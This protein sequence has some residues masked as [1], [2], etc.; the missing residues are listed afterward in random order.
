ME[1][2]RR[3][4]VDLGDST[5]WIRI[6][7]ARAGNPPLLLVQ[8][9]PGLP[10]L[11]EVPA[12]RRLALEDDFTVVYWDQRGCGR[13]LRSAAA[14]SIEAMVDDTVRLLTILAD[15]FGRPPVV[16]G[17]SMGATISAYAAARRPDL[18]SALVTVGMDIDGPAI[19]EN[20]YR[21]ALTTARARRHRRAIR[22]LEAIGPPPHLRPEQFA[23]R[24]RWNMTLCWYWTSR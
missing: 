17:F 7:A 23:T 22:Q 14:L 4:S 6:R 20:A 18:V 5:Q 16:A 9:G 24:A 19:E 11:N 12:F 21:F 2:D 13:S 15:R 10:M 1:L 3:E 8:M